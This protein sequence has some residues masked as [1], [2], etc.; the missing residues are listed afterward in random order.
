[1]K[2]AYILLCV[3]MLINASLFAQNRITG[4]I[5]DENSVPIIGATIFLP[6]MN[7][8]TIADTEGHFELTNIP[9][10][11]LKIQFSMLGFSTKIENLELKGNLVELNILMKQVAVEYEEIVVSG[12]SSSSQH[13][14]AVKIDKLKINPLNTKSTPNFAEVLTKI[15]GVD[16]IS[17]GP[18]VSKPVIRGLSMNDIL[19]LSNGVRFENYQYS[20]HHPLGIDE[21]GIDEVEI[22]KGP[23]SLLYGSDAIGGVINFIKEKPA[24]VGS[25]I[26]DYNM[27]LFSNTLGMT[28]N[29]GLRGSSGK[30]F[31]GI[32]VGQKTNSDFLQ[33]GGEYVP[34][35]RFNEWSAK[36]NA[37]FTSKIGTFKLF[38]DY[39]NQNLGLVEEEAIDQILERGRK[40][41]LFY[42]Q[43][44]MHLLSSQNKFYLGKFRLDINSAFQNTE[45]AHFEAIN[46][47]ELQMKLK[48]LTYETKLYLPSSE[49]SEYIIGFQGL[50]QTNSNLNDRETILLPNATTSNYSVFGMIQQALLKKVKLQAGLRYDNKSIS[51]QSVGLPSDEG[52]REAVDKNFESFSGSIG[53]TVQ[54]TEKLLFRSNFAAAYRT[55]NLAEL[56]SNG[57]HETRYEMGNSN[58]VPENS[59]EMDMSLHYHH[60]N[61]TFDLAGFYNK[62][63]NYIYISPTRDTS[64]TGLPV[65][66]YFQ[67][68]SALYGGEAG[69]HIHPKPLEW[70]HFELTYATVIGKQQNDDYLPFIPANKFNIEL[71]GEAKKLT[72]L[73]NA[74]VSINSST[75]FNQPNAAPDETTTNGYTLVDL[76]FGGSI[77]LKNQ[78]ISIGISANNLFDIK[79]IDHLSTLKEVNFY[80]PGRN[81]T[82]SLKVP[83]GISKKS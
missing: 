79:Y 58:L 71:R 16:M 54:I 26:G 20:S 25:I 70:L 41:E 66:R 69:I 12:I 64:E 18:G 83:F 24:P 37:G 42:Q 40:N 78:Y 44:N 17:K 6:E 28:N 13:E 50:N 80:N 38:Y 60:D 34:N 53:A 15:P 74:F 52:F 65:Y 55:P 21:F 5:I 49:K 76:S 57:Q 8:G 22:I 46:V 11:K 36:A 30:F 63:D 39:N 35:S 61:I 82:F 14:N 1:M 3:L 77:K 31:G 4:K 27:Q 9:N 62:I 2:K 33:G 51:T 19:I 32:R 67:T 75:A 56:T 81:I 72:F 48:T 29:L 45:L 68:N 47:Y 43:L 10:G 7:K 73:T 23:A 59:Y